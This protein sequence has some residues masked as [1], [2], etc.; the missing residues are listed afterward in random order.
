MNGVVRITP[1]C[2]ASINYTLF[3]LMIFTEPY[4]TM[5]K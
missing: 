2:N 5:R 3:I 4:I 1:Y